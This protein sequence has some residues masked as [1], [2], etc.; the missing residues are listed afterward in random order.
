MLPHFG[1]V[2]HY[3]KNDQVELVHFREV[4]ERANYK[5]S[6]DHES[7]LFTEADNEDEDDDDNYD[8]LSDD[9]TYC[10]RITDQADL[11]PHAANQEM[12]STDTV[13]EWTLDEVPQISA[14]G[15]TWS[16]E[17]G[18]PDETQETT[19]TV[20]ERTQERLGCQSGTWDELEE[21]TWI[22]DEDTRDPVG[23]EFLKRGCCARADRLKFEVLGPVCGQ[24]S[25]AEDEED[26]GMGT[27]IGTP[28]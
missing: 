9:A 23:N 20:S 17:E 16:L 10:T 3:T 18:S 4:L 12:T 1:F 2:L 15:E 27:S 5:F 24:F 8:D 14:E 19:E 25:D 6:T 13:D 22:P 28:V 21:D 11:C 7:V 26:A